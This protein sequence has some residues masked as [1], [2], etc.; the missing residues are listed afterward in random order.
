VTGRQGR[1]CKHLLNEVKTMRGCC[2]LRPAA[3]YLTLWR[4]GLE[5]SY[6]PVVRRIDSRVNEDKIT[7]HMECK[8]KAIPVIKE[9]LEPSQSYAENTSATQLGSTK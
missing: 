2:E 6:G 7:E 9:E 8:R 5:R 4:K 1:R 3:L